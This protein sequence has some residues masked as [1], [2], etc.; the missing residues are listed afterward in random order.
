MSDMS[1]QLRCLLY[2]IYFDWFSKGMS[3]DM[4]EY[5]QRPDRMRDFKNNK[6]NNKNR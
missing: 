2:S 1:L 3:L 6:N 5:T 4:S